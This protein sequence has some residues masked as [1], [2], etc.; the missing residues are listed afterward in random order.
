MTLLPRKS[1]TCT[2]NLLQTLEK[3]SKIIYSLRKLYIISFLWLSMGTSDLLAQ[4][5][6]P[7]DEFLLAREYAANNELEKAKSILE[8]LSKKQEHTEMIYT[9]YLKVLDQLGQ[10]EEKNKYLKK[11]TKK[12]PNNY[13]FFIDYNIAA[14]QNPNQEKKIVKELQSIS[15]A[16][17]NQSIEIGN[18]LIIKELYSSSIYYLEEQRSRFNREELFTT[19]LAKLNKIQGNKE[20]YYHE[21]MVHLKY[22]INEIQKVQDEL[23]AEV[24]SSNTD[25]LEKKVY[26]FLQK[27]PTNT[28]YPKL[29]VWYYLQKKDY[30]QAF[31]QAKALDKRLLSRNSII[32]INNGKLITCLSVAQAAHSSLQYTDAIKTYEYIVAN[33]SNYFSKLEA[34]NDLIDCKN[35]M[36]QSTYPIDTMAVK[37]LIKDYDEILNSRISTNKK[38]DVY[39]KVAKL[40]A[41]YLHDLS[42]AEKILLASDKQAASS[43]T[44]AKSKIEL[45][46]IYLLKNEPW[47]STLLYYQ[48]E[49]LAKEEDTGHQAKLKNAKLSYY[50]SNFKLAKERLDILKRATSR[51]ISN[52]AIDLSL[53]IQ[54]NLFEDSTGKSLGAYAAA[55][56][57]VFQNRYTDAEKKL[58]SISQ[59]T[60]AQFLMDE[61]LWLRS[62]INLKKNEFSKAAANLEI[63]ISVYDNRALEDDA[64]FRLA[65]LYQYH[66]DQ[67]EKAKNLY[68]KILTDYPESLYA[69]EARKKFRAIRGDNVN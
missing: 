49:K 39:R 64:I 19:E 59:L 26:S 63:L 18:Y 41:Y 48:A 30:G 27:N 5:L 52:D 60:T 22:H 20:K 12:Y 57:L 54:N 44:K 42:T 32:R 67:E 3:T 24:V 7:K 16:N 68:Q 21:L 10:K 34:K 38:V 51:K 65:N 1:R 2:I 23:Q 17:P 56:L 53:L 62:D 55:E 36:I 58:D 31:M 9:S 35:E 45:A 43:R 25:I 6:S 66:L 33:T 11:L 69:A 40:H 14:F 28:G 15:N 50:Q 4:S 8:K 46:D 13:K 37:S 29:L 47:E 61:I